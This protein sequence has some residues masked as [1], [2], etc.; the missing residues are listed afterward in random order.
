MLDNYSTVKVNKEDLEQLKQLY[1]KAQPG[2]IFL[3]KDKQILK[4]Y[5]KYMIEYLEK[6]FSKGAI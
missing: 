2:E 6:Q 1:G 4:E 5:A 3:F